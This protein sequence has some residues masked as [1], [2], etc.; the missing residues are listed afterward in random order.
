MTSLLIGK[1]GENKISTNP[2]LVMQHI[3]ITS[4]LIGKSG[5]KILNKKIKQTK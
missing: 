3:R 1:S 5:K 2:K 4:F